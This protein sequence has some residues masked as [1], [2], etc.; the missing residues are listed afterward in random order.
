[1]A[2]HEVFPAYIFPWLNSISILCLAFMK[3]TK[4]TAATLTNL[5]GGSTNNEG[6]GLFSLTLDWQYITSSSMSL[7]L[8]LQVHQA[9]GFLIC[10]AAMLGIYYT[11]TWDAKSLPFMST[12]LWTAGDK[13]CPISKIFVGGVLDKTAFAR[14]G[15]P[16][17]TSSFAYAFFMTNDTIGAVIA[18]CAMF[19]GGDFVKAYKSLRA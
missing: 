17:L 14:F 6:L 13:A 15:I 16:R 19:W 10:F 5:F 18:H 12:R 9:I 3:A 7:P 4:S 1:M 2:V 11:N 8:K